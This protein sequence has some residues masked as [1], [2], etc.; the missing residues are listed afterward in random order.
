MVDPVLV[1]VVC[2]FSG[3]SG[4]YSDSLFNI[5]TILEYEATWVGA[6]SVYCVAAAPDVATDMGHAH[7]YT[8]LVGATLRLR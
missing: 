3:L 7:Y 4:V 1:T 5:S 8:D 2:V 6:R